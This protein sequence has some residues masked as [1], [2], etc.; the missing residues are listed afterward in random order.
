MTSILSGHEANFMIQYRW[1][2]GKKA[3]KEKHDMRRVIDLNNV[4]LQDS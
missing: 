1:E 3:R 2:Y 4:P